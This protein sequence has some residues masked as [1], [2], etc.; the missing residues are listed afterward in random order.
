MLRQQNRDPDLRQIR[1]RQEIR[2]E[3]DKAKAAFWLGW[4]RCARLFSALPRDL[5]ECRSVELRALCNE[6]PRTPPGPE[7]S[8]GTGIASGA[9]DHPE[10]LSLK[11][12]DNG[13]AGK[14][15]GCSFCLF[16]EN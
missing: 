6:V 1:E 8:N 10:F 5:C 2:N 13:Q 7:G 16:A 12:V 3:L 15:R 9:A 4:G 11:T 14:P